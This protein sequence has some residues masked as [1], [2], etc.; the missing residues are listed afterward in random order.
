LVLLLLLLLLLS[1]HDSCKPLLIATY[2]PEE[3][4][5]REHLLD[6][7]AIC[8]SA[9]VPGSSD[10]RVAAIDA[11]VRFQDTPDKVFEETREM[12]E[13]LNSS[14]SSTAAGLTLS[15]LAAGATVPRQ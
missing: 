3:G 15:P 9:D 4:P 5:L 12:T 7:I 11:A 6:R 14:V 10:E 2:N 1:P 8:L 13:G